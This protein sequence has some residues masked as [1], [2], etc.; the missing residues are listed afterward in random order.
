MR[1]RVWSAVSL[2]VASAGLVA[3]FDL[4][5]STS[6]ILT[7]CQLDA[8]A[9]DDG[10]ARVDAA[11]DA[12]TDFRTFTPDQAVANAQHA[13]AWLGAC[14]TPLGSNAFGTCMFDA[15][16][17]YDV[18]ANPNHPVRGETHALWDCLWQVQSCADVARCVFPAAPPVCGSSGDY[19]ACG[20]AG[21]VQANASVRIECVDGGLAVGE[22][23]A[24]MGRTCASNGASAICAGAAGDAGLACMYD[25]CTGTRLHR[26]GGG[27]VDLGIDCASNGSGQCAGFPSDTNPAWVACVA[28]GDAGCAASTTVQCSGGY[29][30]SCASGV[31]EVIDCTELLQVLDPTTTTCMPGPLPNPFDWTSPCVVADGGCTADSCDA[32]SVV[33]C[34]RGAPY[35]VNCA[36]Q[37][38]GPCTMVAT[39]VGT[40]MNAA[41]TAP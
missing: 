15:L 16:L 23:C 33:G 26:C 5:H 27:G 28:S 14:E 11:T 10:G 18:G 25:D 37:G 4:F 40:A 34:A 30:T 7:E 31:T 32:G 36:S 1:L 19:T 21:G 35:T 6:G 17:A 13:C 8:Q 12:G 24:L 20:N 41:C 39:D 22:N 2:A 9:C 38:L 29:A 3:C